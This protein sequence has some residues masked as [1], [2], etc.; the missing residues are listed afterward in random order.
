[1]R[2]HRQRELPPDCVAPCLPLSV[3]T[4]KKKKKFFVSPEEHGK[5][6]HRHK[7]RNK[8]E[9]EAQTFFL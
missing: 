1:M 4:H 7:E 5:N 3:H 6:T 8:M 9:F 2:A